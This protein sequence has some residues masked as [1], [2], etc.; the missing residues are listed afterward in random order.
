MGLKCSNLA[1]DMNANPD[2]SALLQPDLRPLENIIPRT[3]R[4]LIVG[5]GLDTAILDS[6]VAASRLGYTNVF[7]AADA[8]RAAHFGM[9]GEYGSGFL[10]DPAYVAAE[11][12]KHNI[13]AVQVSEVLRTFSGSP[14]MQ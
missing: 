13:G 14:K 8:C 3:G 9:S 2:L 7:V 4:L 10:T 6:A 5:L 1:N 12:Q 11:F